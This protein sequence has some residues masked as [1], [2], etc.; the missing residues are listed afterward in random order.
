M[1]LGGPR[2][3]YSDHEVDGIKINYG[4]LGCR[5]FITDLRLRGL[6]RKIRNPMTLKNL[7]LMLKHHESQTW[8]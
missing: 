7:S 2:R 6:V 3:N 4:S 5:D 1:K 8:N